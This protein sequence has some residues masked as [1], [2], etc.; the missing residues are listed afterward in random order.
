MANIN[1]GLFNISYWIHCQ[2]V[3]DI[4]GK[5]FINEDSVKHKFLIYVAPPERMVTLDANYVRT[6]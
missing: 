4:I 1:V 5:N 2:A 6:M 3:H